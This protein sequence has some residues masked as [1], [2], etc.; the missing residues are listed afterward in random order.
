MGWVSEYARYLHLIILYIELS[1]RSFSHQNMKKK[2]PNRCEIRSP[3]RLNR[4]NNNQFDFSTKQNQLAYWPTLGKIQ[5]KKYLHSYY[6]TWNKKYCISHFWEMLVDRR[7]TIAITEEKSSINTH[8]QL[9]KYL[10]GFAI[11]HSYKRKIHSL[12]RDISQ[13][14]RQSSSS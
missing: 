13:L 1:L 6:S 10:T 12:I 7:I 4:T 3:L 5:T 9:Y 14:L 2:K 11:I 8:I